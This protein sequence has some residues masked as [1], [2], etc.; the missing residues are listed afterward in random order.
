MGFTHRVA[1][2]ARSYQRLRCKAM[3]MH[4]SMVGAGLA[5]DRDVIYRSK[6]A[7]TP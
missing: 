2:K 1:G 7:V 3:V 4:A 5:R 6:I